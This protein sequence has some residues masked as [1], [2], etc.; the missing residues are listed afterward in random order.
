MTKALH[1]WATNRVLL[2]IV[3]FLCCRGFLGIQVEAAISSVL[4]TGGGRLPA[5]A[6]YDAALRQMQRAYNIAPNST[7]VIMMMGWINL[8]LK[9][10]EEARFYF[11]RVL[12]IDD[13]IEEAQM[14]NAFVSLETGRGELSSAILEKIFEGRQSDPNVRILQAG[15]LVREGHNWQAAAIYRK[16]A[17]DR[18]LCHGVAELALTDLFGLQGFNDCPGS[19]L[20][21]VSRPARRRFPTV[22]PMAPCGA[23]G[24]AG[25]RSSTS[26]ASTWVPARPVTTQARR[27]PTVR[28][29]PAGSKTRLT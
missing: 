24:P 25:G 20:Q 11:Q 5:R 16:L 3:D 18:Q 19:E 17:H 4:R 23:A 14:G 1:R 26:P 27:R 21:P 2:G 10:Y 29:T 13:R 7:D 15:A 12:K 6:S 28:P 22:P 8:K 9:H